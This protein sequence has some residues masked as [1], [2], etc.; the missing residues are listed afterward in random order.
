MFFYFN[1]TL[2]FIQIF[3]YKII[4]KL[5]WVVPVVL[6]SLPIVVSLTL[7]GYYRLHE[8]MVAGIFIGTFLTVM[9]FSVSFTYKDFGR[10]YSKKIIKVLYCS[11]FYN[12]Y[13]YFIV[14]Q[15]IKIHKKDETFQVSSLELVTKALKMA[16]KKDK[17]ELNKYLRDDLFMYFKDVFPNKKNIPLNTNEFVD[18][19]VFP[20]SLQNGE[21]DWLIQNLL[22]DD[23][24][25]SN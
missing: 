18:S 2:S 25:L 6:A 20:R 17:L 1:I 13:N 3:L 9:L 11:D 16:K 7:A 24:I 8:I 12:F 5:L 4:G 14:F 23:F 10:W 19:N 15:W 21:W 22:F